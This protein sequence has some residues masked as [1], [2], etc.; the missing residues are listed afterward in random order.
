MSPTTFRRRPHRIATAVAPVAA[1]LLVAGCVGG[2]TDG[3]EDPV[4]PGEGTSPSTEPATEDDASNDALDL[5]G[6]WRVDDAEGEDDGTYL[7]VDETEF[8]VWRSCGV[9][10]VSWRASDDLLLIGDII[11]YVGDCHDTDDLPGELPWLSDATGFEFTDDGWQLV[12][13]QGAVTATFTE[14]GSPEPHPDVSDAL[15]EAPE[16]TDHARE[17]L[18]AHAALAQD[19]TPPSPEDL[20][21]RWVPVEDA[22]TEPFA[23]FNADGTWGGSDGCNDGGG[24]WLTGDDGT[25]LAIGGPMTQIGC[26]GENV[27]QVLETARTVAIDD[28]VLSFFDIDG[29]EILQ[30]QRDAA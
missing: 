14:D 18:G 8:M 7:R 23:E 3:S 5:I 30:L 25:F 9:D 6:M 24:R 28:D 19:L 15:I 4:T 16:I 10:F 11:A 1:A 17:R 2:D 13:A 21:G 12:D 29:D 20:E 26:E 27:P 22:G